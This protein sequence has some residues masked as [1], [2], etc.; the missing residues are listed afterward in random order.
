MKSIKSKIVVIFILSF[1][2]IA[3]LA[4]F[5]WL[6]SNRLKNDIEE[7]IRPKE[8]SIIIKEIASKLSRLNSLY[9]KLDTDEGII[10]EHSL[11]IEELKNDIEK[12][13]KVYREEEDLSI[14]DLE[15]I[16]ESL[17]SIKHA[18]IEVK[19]LKNDFYKT[20]SRRLENRLL[21]SIES[22]NIKDLVYIENNLVTEITQIIEKDFVFIDDSVKAESS[23]FFQRLFGRNR[24]KP[25]D[26][27]SGRPNQIKENVKIDTILHVLKDSIDAKYDTLRITEGLENLKLEL[28]RMLIAEQNTALSIRKKE[29][30]LYETNLNVIGNLEKII[31]SYQINEE[32]RSEKLAQ[33]TLNTTQTH[34]RVILFV[35]GLFG[36]F[37]LIA[38]GFLMRDI[39]RSKY[40]QSRLEKS[41]KEIS[42]RFKQKQNL[43]NT[44]SHEIRTP[45]TS[46]MGFADL[47][48]ENNKEFKEAILSNSQYLLQIA[49]EILD[50]A[51]LEADKIEVNPKPT[52]LVET[53]KK[54]QKTMLP[55][56]KAADL[57][58]EFEYPSGSIWVELDSYRLQQILYNLMHN[59]IKFTPEGSVKMKALVQQ[60]TEENLDVSISIED[61]G[62]GMD[63]EELKKVFNDYHQS[64]T[65][66][67]K[68]Q[69]I[70]LGLGIVKKLVQ[71]LNGELKVKSSKGK[72][73]AFIIT[74]NL[75]KLEKPIPVETSQANSLISKVNLKGLKIAV[76]DDD[77]YITKLYK[78]ILGKSGATL[79]IFNDP[80]K[81]L[82]T[83]ESSDKFNILFSDIV[84]PQL[85]GTE[86]I[87]IIDSNVK[88]PDYV[89][90]AT[91]N[92]FID[93]IDETE[94]KQFD[95]LLTKPFTMETLFDA[96]R[97]VYPDRFTGI[98]KQTQ[99]HTELETKE[100]LFD[101]SALK[102]FTQDDEDFLHELL[103]EMITQNEA[104]LHALS[105]A[106]ES[107]N[108]EASADLVHKLSSRF[109]QIKARGEINTRNT[110]IKLRSGNS[111]AL[112]EASLALKN[113]LT[114]NELLKK[115]LK[116]INRD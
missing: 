30:D 80:Y 39:N 73:T 23:N 37:S 58:S 56:V 15:N 90:A 24:E 4:T 45:L 74:L 79:S 5:S 69:G 47:L 28:S 85:K 77:P 13:K 59:A 25:V 71:L 107:E 70:G 78:N 91:A 2:A 76:L 81:F 106:L 99:H 103:E 111:I 27:T 31:Y 43:L 6:I 11:L 86:L 94:L 16:P 35:I 75:K 46:I 21:E 98:E 1:F 54:I 114:I 93:S 3:G 51:K 19:K 100:P 26:T 112:K 48:P 67:S 109:E 52:D 20:F 29:Q 49:N 42:K 62:V 97:S 40:Y 10:F 72:G 7:L 9:L 36:M 55:L 60:E 101:L 64:G 68:M 87:K 63:T 96:I 22:A 65:K 84:M 61:T 14:N 102:E 83:W 89:I 17:D 88:R 116:G 18:Y 34:Q 57:D 38:I 115:E 105:D 66:N 44:L 110:E 8:K 92:I 53:L 12:L 104:D 113:W 108:A 33:E 82:K 32:I 41:E 95:L 50:L